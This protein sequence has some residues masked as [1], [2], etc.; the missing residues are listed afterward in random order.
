MRG[1]VLLAVTTVLGLGIAGCSSYTGGVS[2]SGG[3]NADDGAGMVA[4]SNAEGGGG[5]T[6]TPVSHPAAGSGAGLTG[7]SNR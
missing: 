4:S 7:S 2:V 1:L 6:A 3:G 5:F